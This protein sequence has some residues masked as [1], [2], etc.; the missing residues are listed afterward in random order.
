MR[1]VLV[2]CTGFVGGNLAASHTFSACYHSTDIAE[3]YGT[4]PDLVVYAGIRAEKFLANASP[5]EDRVAVMQAY[6]NL[7][8]MQP[9]KVVLISTADVYQTPCNVDER[10]AVETQGLHP[11]G[12]HRFELE[13]KVRRAFPDALIVRLPALYG[14][15]LK[16]NF[17]YDLL[18]VTPAM[19]KENV[20]AAL[21]EKNPCIAGCYQQGHNGFYKLKP[22]SASDAAALRAW[23]SQNDFNALSFTDSRAVYQFYPLSRLWADIETAL[24]EDIPL[25]NATAAPLSAAEIH[26]AVTGRAF[27]NQLA[28]PPVYYDIKSVYA[29]LFGGDK[30]YFI[31]REE[32]LRGIAAFCQT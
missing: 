17:L 30:D 31:G 3:S 12:L 4:K 26:K 2:G 10:T 27:C 22:L 28:S 18:T 1:S 7:T 9:K 21:C 20:Y 29:P 24:K 8:K 13:Q 6:E 19:L 32:T 23:F 11:Y 5:E 15:G 14:K 25:L 16:K